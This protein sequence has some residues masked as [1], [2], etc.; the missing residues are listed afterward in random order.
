[1]KV[2]SNFLCTE[3]LNALWTQ[4]VGNAAENHRATR[5]PMV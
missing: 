5:N 3:A 1:M 4:Q 2:I